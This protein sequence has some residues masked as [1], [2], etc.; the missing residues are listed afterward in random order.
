MV[1]VM[2]NYRVELIGASFA[3]CQTVE[4]SAPTK[5]MALEKIKNGDYNIIESEIEIL[6]YAEINLDDVYEEKS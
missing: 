1:D 5:E 3:S 6:D 2:N 4:T